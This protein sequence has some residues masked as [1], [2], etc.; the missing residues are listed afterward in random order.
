MITVCEIQWVGWK[1][2]WA[3]EV[4]SISIVTRKTRTYKLKEADCARKLLTADVLLVL[5]SVSQAEPVF[6]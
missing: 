2:A 6:R 1:C 4:S 3:V 5:G